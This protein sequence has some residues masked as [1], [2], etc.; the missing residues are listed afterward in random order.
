MGKDC[1]PC[2]KPIYNCC[3]PQKGPRGPPGYH[4]WTGPAG[5]GGIQG[6]TGP[7]GATGIAG[8]GG[9]AWGSSTWIK[10]EGGDSAEINW[11][12]SD[13]GTDSTFL[14]LAVSGTGTVTNIFDGG[15]G[16]VANADVVEPIGMTVVTP[17]KYQIGAGFH[18]TLP[19]MPTDWFTI[20]GS[21]A[22]VEL[23]ISKDIVN[24]PGYAATD[25][26]EI[27]H[28]VAAFSRNA[29]VH[30]QVVTTLAAGDTISPILR[31]NGYSSAIDLLDP[32][33]IIGIDSMYF[34]MSLI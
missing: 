30:G 29:S 34:N 22:N 10:D 20:P 11:P 24:S 16:L 32:G 12:A 26:K 8:T 7:P 3:N 19:F 2:Y 23:H 1:Q 14:G 5:V 17:G 15:G 13:G 28:K 33:T 25:I 9:I 4:G 27:S 6:W 18:M 21:V 31:V